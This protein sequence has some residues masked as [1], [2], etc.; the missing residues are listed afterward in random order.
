MNDHPSFFELDLATLG[1]GT[2]A[3]AGHCAQCTECRVY[4]AQAAV[5]SQPL[6]VW[7]A[8]STQ[9]TAWPKVRMA[10]GA[11][12][13]ALLS[14]WGVAQWLKA[15]ER[16]TRPKGQPSF[17]FFVE[18]A[19][20][21]TLWNGH[22]AVSAGDR[23]QLKTAAAG[24]AFLRVAVETEGTWKPLFAAPVSLSGETA[25]PESWRVDAVDR[26]MRLGLLL[27]A[28]ECGESEFVSAAVEHQRNE[29]FWFTEFQFEQGVTP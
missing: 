10:F 8:A 20:T 14:V 29:R 18:R 11:L 19:G 26:S 23:L 4:L 5:G 2:A 21:V 25:L 15:P 28:R 7:L 1:Q 6:P 17:A 13:V 16:D 3:T 24:Y 9:R 27:C 12:A 22:D